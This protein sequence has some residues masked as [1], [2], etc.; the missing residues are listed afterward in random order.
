MRACVRGACHDQGSGLLS[1]VLGLLVFASQSYSEV[2]HIWVVGGAVATLACVLSACFAV[3]LSVD[4][5]AMCRCTS[6]HG[7]GGFAAFPTAL[8]IAVAAAC[9]V[10]VPTWTLLHHQPDLPRG[11]VAGPVAGLAIATAALLLFFAVY[12]SPEFEQLFPLFP[13]PQPGDADYDLLK[14]HAYALQKA[15]KGL[16]SRVTV[17][18]WLEY[19]AYEGKADTRDF[20]LAAMLFVI[21]VVCAVAIFVAVFYGLCF[22]PDQ[23]W[24]W[25]RCFLLAIALHV[26]VLQPLK[27]CG[28]YLFWRVS[29]G[30]DPNER[31]AREE[32]ERLESVTN[33]GLRDR[34]G[35]VDG[36]TLAMLTNGGGDAGGGGGGS[37]TYAT[38]HH[39]HATD[40]TSS[41]VRL[42][43]QAPDR[44]PV[45]ASTQAAG[46]R[47][48]RP[49]P[50]TGYRVEYTD[51]MH[52][53]RRVL[54]HSTATD[55][56]IGGGKGE[57]ASTSLQPGTLLAD[58][59]VV[60][61]HKGKAVTRASNAIHARTMRPPSRPRRLRVAGA[62]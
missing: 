42:K 58:V 41:T 6:R 25:L 34:R 50:I 46:G 53:R 36:L 5:R 37:R 45:A 9:Q 59:Q 12:L 1:I 57:P 17:V 55:F 39:L 62:R 48:V 52:I 44:K 43:W 35:S 51:D 60:A 8:C 2:A 7:W 16:R 28:L 27:A 61:L 33:M 32:R 49:R 47:R 4:P 29:D 56:V 20:L 23:A 31:K 14:R 3:S 22:L 11:M 15:F 21:A 10:G 24:A 38:P 30:P 18:R 26:V 13:L 19:E 54:T 40:I